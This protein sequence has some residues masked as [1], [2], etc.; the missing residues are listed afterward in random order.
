MDIVEANKYCTFNKSAH[1]VEVL[2]QDQMDFFVMELEF[3]ETHDGARNYWSGGT[4]WNREGQW[5]WANSLLPVEDFV[6]HTGQPDGG[7]NGGNYLDFYSGFNYFGSDYPG[8]GNFY[9]ICQKPMT[10]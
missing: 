8:T 4:D 10:I 9:P 2:T 6:W 1:L 7:L 3:L 5:Y